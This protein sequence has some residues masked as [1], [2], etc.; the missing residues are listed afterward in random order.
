MYYNKLL[1]LWKLAARLCQ[2]IT[3]QLTIPS[4]FLPWIH[5]KTFYSLDCAI[6][7]RWWWIMFPYT[8]WG[9]VSRNKVTASGI[10]YIA[11]NRSRFHHGD[12]DILSIL[13][14]AIFMFLLFRI[15]KCAVCFGHQ[16]HSYICITTAFVDGTSYNLVWCRRWGLLMNREIN[17]WIWKGEL[18]S[19]NEIPI[20][21]VP[22]VMI[23]EL[24]LSYLM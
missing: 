4:I 23:Y 24:H 9:R 10:R 1:C 16:V 6:M 7:V 22:L 17:N 18:Y 3:W 5:P 12:L 19:F 13:S 8:W 15:N 2:M 20:T 11:A 21:R 14:P